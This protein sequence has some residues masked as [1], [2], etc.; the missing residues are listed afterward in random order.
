MSISKS[1][2]ERKRREQ[3]IRRIVGDV[4]Y[5]A[6][7][8]AY[9][10]ADAVQEAARFVRQMRAKSGLSQL[11][12]GKRIGVSQAR[13]SEIEKGGSPE[14]VSYALLKRVARACGLPDW[15]APPVEDEAAVQIATSALR[16]GRAAADA[17]RPALSIRSRGEVRAAANWAKGTLEMLDAA[18]KEFPDAIIETVTIL[19]PT[20]GGAKSF[21][22]GPEGVAPLPEGRS[23]A[24][25]FDADLFKDLKQH[26]SGPAAPPFL[27]K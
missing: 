1:A 16:L 23:I 25:S 12:L 21:F 27:K 26:L 11:E 20:P 13:I 2:N 8:D 17:P 19:L 14:G 24:A 5:D 6:N 9:E 18:S 10:N 4:H 7:R 22:L 3:A 15:P